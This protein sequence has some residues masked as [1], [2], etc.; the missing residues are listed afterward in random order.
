MKLST[1]PTSSIH[2]LLSSSLVLNNLSLQ[3]SVWTQL[4]LTNRRGEGNERI[5]VVVFAVVARTIY[6][7]APS[8][9]FVSSKGGWKKRHWD[10]SPVF[11]VAWSEP[12]NDDVDAHSTFSRVA[13]R[14][15]QQVLLVWHG[16]FSSRVTFH[17]CL[18]NTCAT[19]KKDRA[20]SNVERVR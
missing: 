2:D 13:F 5:P 6:D 15:T 1:A 10:C 7:D 18:S 19:A 9:L 8:N 11:S 4:Y 12:H 17:R 20:L 16:S 14:S 3:I